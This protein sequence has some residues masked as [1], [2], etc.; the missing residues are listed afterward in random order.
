MSHPGYTKNIF[1][2]ALGIWRFYLL[3]SPRRIL[4]WSGVNF[5]ACDSG[6]PLSGQNRGGLHAKAQPAAVDWKVALHPGNWTDVTRTGTTSQSWSSNQHFSM[7]IRSFWGE[8][9]RKQCFAVSL[10]YLILLDTNTKLYSK[11]H[12]NPCIPLVISCKHT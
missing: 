10:I 11:N 4:S 3:L 5:T 6:S 8:A 9:G 12:W 7:D 2:H 1:K